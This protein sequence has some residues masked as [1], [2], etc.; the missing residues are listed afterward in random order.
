MEHL[1]LHNKLGRYLAEY[2]YQAR[3]NLEAEWAIFASEERITA[4]THHR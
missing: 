4:E 1:S 3:R 2:Q